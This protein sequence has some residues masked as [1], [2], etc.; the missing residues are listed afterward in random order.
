MLKDLHLRFFEEFWPEMKNARKRI[1]ELEK[2][3]N[4]KIIKKT[5]L[6]VIEGDFIKGR[7]KPNETS[8][9]EEKKLIKK[10]Q[11]GKKRKIKKFKRW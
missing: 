2:D 7:S 8:I 11:R 5:V 4:N 9:K 1:N 6:W 10:Y 3:G